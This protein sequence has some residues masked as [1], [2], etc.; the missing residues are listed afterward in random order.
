M[1]SGLG[2]PN[3]GEFHMKLAQ[4]LILRGDLQKRFA[5]L[6]T[7][8]GKNAVVQEGSRPH[9]APEELLAEAEGV[10]VELED[11]ICRINRTNVENTL[12]DG[13]TLTEAVARRDSLVQ[14]HSLLLHAIE[15]AQTVPSRFGLAEIR[16][17]ATL[18]VPKLRKQADGVAEEIRKLNA[19][20]QER[21][22]TVDL[23]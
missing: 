18:D 21:N 6:R 11:L 17:L 12:A 13:Q 4:A 23:V 1:K 8:V 10:L 19:A 22:W 16:W 15:S 2:T 9:E 14:R 7:R 20:L 5:S 3:P